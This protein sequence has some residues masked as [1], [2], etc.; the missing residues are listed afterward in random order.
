MNWKAAVAIGAGLALLFGFMGWALCTTGSMDLAGAS[1]TSLAV[2]VAGVLA[3][4]LLA[5]VLI[6]LA[7]YS[8]RKGYDEPPRF[9]ADRAKE[10]PKPD[11][12]C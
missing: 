8:S 6:A 5:G 1:T 7:F 2:I 4:G 10:A 3:T 12:S 9:G 11:R